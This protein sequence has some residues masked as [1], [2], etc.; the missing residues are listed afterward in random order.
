M[1][2]PVFMSREH[3]ALMNEKLAA[4]AEVKRICQALR[5][6]LALAFEL[7]NG[8]GGDPTWWVLTFTDVA[9]FSLEPSPAADVI[10]RGDWAHMIRAT[11]SP[12]TV[13]TDALGVPEGIVPH[14]NVSVLPQIM[15]LLAAIR[16]HGAVPVTMPEVP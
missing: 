15:E 1:P 8:P 9:R 12:G 16:P 4:S 11:L 13:P 2:A 5:R 3:V 14:G 10:L 7:A 6:E